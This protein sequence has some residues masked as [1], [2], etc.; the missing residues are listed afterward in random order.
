MNLIHN[1]LLVEFSYTWSTRK[2]FSPGSSEI[3]DEELLIAP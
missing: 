3:V 1:L 2:V